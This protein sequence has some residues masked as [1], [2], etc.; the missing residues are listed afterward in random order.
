V[1]WNDFTGTG[2]AQLYL[3]GSSA[4][5]EIPNN[6]MWGGTAKCSAVVSVAG[7]GTSVGDLKFYEAKFY[8]V[9]VAG[10]T[11]AGIIDD[12][13]V[14]LDTGGFDGASSSVSILADDINDAITVTLTNIP[15]SAGSETSCT[16]TLDITESGY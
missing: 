9:N 3:N 12:T 5:L 13:N 10:T 14:L 15:G 4:L 16:C 8:A 6:T 2:T 7:T 1:A 11:T